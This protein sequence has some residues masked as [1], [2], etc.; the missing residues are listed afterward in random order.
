MHV[1]QTVVRHHLC[2]SRE[3]GVHTEDTADDRK[4]L[5]TGL[6]SLTQNIHTT[7]NA[8]LINAPRKFVNLMQN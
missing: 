1:A 2:S 7:L 4:F 8:S 3:V 6:L 5:D